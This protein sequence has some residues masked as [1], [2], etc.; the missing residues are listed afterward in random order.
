MINQQKI[1]Y[2]TII[3]TLLKKMKALDNDDVEVTFRACRDREIYRHLFAWGNKCQITEPK[4]L[5]NTYKD[6][7]NDVL[8]TIE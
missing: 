7:S 4:S 6:L 8:K 5:K 2:W 1:A 3:F